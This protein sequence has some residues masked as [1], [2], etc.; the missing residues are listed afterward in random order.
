M[1]NKEI[2]A[3]SE[4]KVKEGVGLL[5]L[6]WKDAIFDNQKDVHRKYY[7]IDLDENPDYKFVS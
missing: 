4:E 5:G 7:G 6:N 2:E 3:V 1:E